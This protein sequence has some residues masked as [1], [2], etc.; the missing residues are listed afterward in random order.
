M[1]TNTQLEKRILALETWRTNVVTPAFLLL[2]NRVKALE[3]RP[4]GTD[5]SVQIANLQAQVDALRT[6]TCPEDGRFA[7]IESALG[8]LNS[9]HIPAP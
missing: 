1:A 6:L 9:D 8:I 2:D 5:Y 4:A 3:A 7:A